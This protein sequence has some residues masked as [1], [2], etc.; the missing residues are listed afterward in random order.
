MLLCT[1]VILNSFAKWSFELEKV[2]FGKLFNISQTLSFYIDNIWFRIFEFS[3]DQFCSL[4]MEFIEKI[5]EA[6]AKLKL[7]RSVKQKKDQMY[8]QFSASI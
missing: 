4:E 3:L 2:N 1:V 7:I 8:I 5:Q 6:H